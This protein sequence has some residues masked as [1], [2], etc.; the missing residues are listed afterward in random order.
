MCSPFT[1][2]VKIKKSRAR[3]TIGDNTEPL[4][5]RLLLGQPSLRH[6]NDPAFDPLPLRDGPR[7]AFPPFQLFSVMPE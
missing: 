2:Q 3:A 1:P 5:A 6:A 7:P 4:F